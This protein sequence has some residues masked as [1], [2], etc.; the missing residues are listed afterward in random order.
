M[1]FLSCLP[2]PVFWRPT[3]IMNMR[4]LSKDDDF[5]SHL[6]VEKLGTGTVPLLVHK[7]D[8]SRR[9]PKT[10]AD[11]LLQ[12]VRRLVITKGPVP[13]VTRQA[14]D[15]LLVLPPI[16]YYLK[17]YTQKQIN[18]FATHASRYFELYH[19]SGCIEIAHTSRYS[20]HTGKSE[21][22]ILATR[23]LA[24]GTVITELKGSMAN[25]S[26]EED[27][28][29]KRTDLRNSDIRRDFSVIHS[30]QMK[31]NHLFL[32]P[33][34]FVNHDCNNNCELFRE[35]KYIT[36]RVLRPIA[37]GEEITAHYG[38]GYFGRKNRHCLC[39][40][41]EKRGRGGY[42]PDHTDEDPPISSDSETDSD[43]DLNSDSDSDASHSDGERKKP[44][45]NLNERRT[46][47]GVYAV[48][49]EG[50]DTDESD[51]EGDDIPTSAPA[52]AAGGGE[53]EL[54]A[55]VDTASDL[56]SLPPS[57]A[58]S[59]AVV[60]GPSTLPTLETPGIASPTPSALTSLSPAMTARS[61]SAL[62]SISSADDLTSLPKSNQ[63]TPFRSIISTRGQK[64]KESSAPA[65]LAKQLMTPP[66][67]ED[68]DTPTKRL[69]R[70]ASAIISSSKRSTG[71]D[72]G[73]QKASQ[74]ATPVPTPSSSR[75]R[76]GKE[77]E[78][79]E[80]DVK[81]EE[82][83]PR[84]LRSR[85]SVP[86]AV[87]VNKEPPPTR[88]TPKDLDGKPLPICSTCSNVLPVISVDSKVV[89]GLEPSSKK[90]KKQ[91]CPRC[92]R[93][94]AIYGQPWPCRVS[95]HGPVF[96]LP[97]PREEATPVESASRRVNKKAL[98]VLDRKL[99]AAAASAS[100]SPKSRKR[101]REE[102]E[103]PMLKRRKTE[104]VLR[105]E[106]TKSQKSKYHK[107]G[108]H[109]LPAAKVLHVYGRHKRGRI[110]RR[111]P[112]PSRSEEESQAEEP[113]EEEVE[114]VVPKVRRKKKATTPQP[115]LSR[116]ERAEERE[117]VRRWLQRK[118]EE[119]AEDSPGEDAAV[120]ARK[121]SSADIEDLEVRP[122]KVLRSKAKQ[123]PLQRVL[124]RPSSGFRGGQLFSKPNP[125]S[126][127]LHAWS[128]PLVSTASSSDDELAPI[129]PEDEPAAGLPLDTLSP[130]FTSPTID[131]TFKPT[132][133][134]FARR[135]WGTG[136]TPPRDES[137]RRVS[138][139]PLDNTSVEEPGLSDLSEAEKDNLF[140]SGPPSSSSVSNDSVAAQTLSWFP[141]PINDD[142]TS[143]LGHRSG[144]Y[145]SPISS[146]DSLSE[147]SQDNDESPNQRTVK[148]TPPSSPLQPDSDS[149]PVPLLRRILSPMSS[150]LSSLDSAP[151]SPRADKEEQS[152]RS[153]EI[154]TANDMHKGPK[155]VSFA[156][157][158]LVSSPHLVDEGWDSFSSPLTSPVES[159][160]DS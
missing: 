67:S 134:S 32:G 26:D 9:L 73:K 108:R 75:T 22:C 118:R 137:K 27:K 37:I 74:A 82:A 38:D 53:I 92:I 42:A 66:L 19:P 152:P 64:A 116:A 87:E 52:D 91:D 95:I 123:L 86:A 147:F 124:P 72:K 70:S 77:K 159:D 20:H 60:A 1:A 10:D 84:M 103:R 48:M 112:S 122:T 133:F 101:Q 120:P 153:L 128:S 62:T 98:S 157:E 132:P 113:P 59:N 18:A 145:S 21:L 28:E 121:R 13:L 80:V 33:A 140:F 88:E 139:N 41:C 2:G 6:L 54:A 130:V 129:T 126:Y 12:I 136:S 78:K 89:W 105:V 151:S 142:G 100:A 63:S 51:E 17:Q 106:T 144:R 65:T 119:E 39:E 135:R 35:G 117:K 15:E 49:P 56:T 93:H 110:R 23:N 149:S 57:R 40:T 138:S 79:D 125:L 47:R 30:K 109:S 155:P 83:E 154:I 146:L 8:S 50:D 141:P 107:N 97:T 31:K 111:S 158:N 61:S 3:K 16:R 143:A 5:L 24:P 25:L 36:F 115:I 45:L 90:K 14:V 104:P 127:A 46:R 58:Q 68:P 44:G 55:E 150:P 34:R 11:D 85:P 69:T 114:K 156:S 131:L 148:Q 81:K 76:K 71:N 102:E 29:L 94:F 99:A 43:S 96:L 160:S 7:M 4:D